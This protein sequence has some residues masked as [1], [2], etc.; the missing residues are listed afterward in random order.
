MSLEA[1]WVVNPKVGSAP[2][3]RGV[4]VLETNRILGGDHASV[5]VGTW[6]FVSNQVDVDVNVNIYDSTWSSYV[7]PPGVTQYQLKGVLTPTPDQRRIIG[8]LHVVGSP[9][10]PIMHVEMYRVAELP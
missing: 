3:L 2:P 1:L 5:W 7:V 6:R 10:S 8:T 4:V 9:S